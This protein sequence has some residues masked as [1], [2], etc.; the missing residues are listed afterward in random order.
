[1]KKYELKLEVK[2][3]KGPDPHI[4]KWRNKYFANLISPRSWPTGRA[5]VIYFYFWLNGDSGN[6]PTSFR[7]DDLFYMGERS[8]A[9][10]FKRGWVVGRKR[11]SKKDRRYRWLPHAQDRRVFAVVYEL[12]PP[13]KFSSNKETQRA[14]MERRRRSLEYF[15]ASDLVHRYAHEADILAFTGGFTFR[16]AWLRA[17]DVRSHAQWILKDLKSTYGV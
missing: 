14:C 10:N 4:T 7:P 16:V 5:E 2:H 1:M 13:P 9:T 15:V 17:G 11:G 8:A 3:S 6:R 12:P